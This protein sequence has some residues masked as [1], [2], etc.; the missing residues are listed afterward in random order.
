MPGLAYELDELVATA[1][2][3]TPDLRPYDAVALFGLVRE[4]RARL[5]DGQLDAV[6]PQALTSEHPNAENRTSVIPRSP[7]SPTL[8]S[9]RAGDPVASAAGQRGRRG[10]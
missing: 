2:A 10:G 3:R 5:S 6:P 4:A 8:G 1:T 7:A 9:A